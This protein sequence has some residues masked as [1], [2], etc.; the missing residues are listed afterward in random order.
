VSPAVRRR[1][2]VALAVAVA[3]VLVAAV[4]LVRGCDKGA[5]PATGAAALVPKDTLVY[6]HVSTDEERGAVEDASALLGRFGSWER[7]RDGVVQRLAGA[8]REVRLERD[9]E[10][11]LGD[12]AALALVDAGGATAGSLVVVAVTDEDRARDFLNRNPARTAERRYKGE[13]I[14]EFG[15][16]AAAFKDGYLLIGQDATVQGA[17]DRANGRGESLQ[18]DETFRRATADLPDDRVADAYAS[19]GGLRRLL[20]PQGDVVGGLAVLLDQPALRGVALS[21]EAGDEGAR[22]RTRSILDPA[23]QRRA[24][25]VPRP[26]EPS[27]T[28]AAP[29]DALAYLGVSGISRSL[30]NLVTAAAGGAQA[31]GAGELLGRLRRELGR[32]TGGNLERDLLGLLEGEVAVVVGR[33]VPAPTLSIVTNVEDEGRTRGVL[34]RLREPL[35]RLL[36]PEGEQAPTWREEDLGDGVRG[37][38][39]QVPGGAALTYAVHDGRLVV[40]TGADAV[41]RITGAEGRLADTD[42][43]EDVTRGRPDEVASVGFLDFSQLLELGEQTG[44]NDNRAYL[45]ARDD[46]RRIRAVGFSSWSTEGETTAELELSIP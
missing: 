13:R 40:G 11:W 24:G 17:L 37:A 2:L 10:P 32:Q 31:G 38:T 23:A 8:G 34:D 1:R 35:A 46:L 16:V 22:V 30:G 41:R 26:F 12:E 36:T 19:A 6:V 9:V 33:A 14:D 21:V 39:L 42:A 20:V 18:Q 44:L 7:I 29:G 43:F 5:P 25:G 45:A 3:V 4:V 15:G 28:D 27:L